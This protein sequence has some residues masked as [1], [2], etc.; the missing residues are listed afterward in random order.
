MHEQSMKYL[1]RNVFFVK[2]STASSEL[3]AHTATLLLWLGR[4]PSG[5]ERGG[6]IRD[7][8]NASPLA[9][10]IGG[11]GARLLF[12]ELLTTLSLEQSPR[13]LL[14]KVSESDLWNAVQDFLQGTWPYEERMDEWN[15]YQIACFGVG[16]AE[17]EQAV[18]VLC[19]C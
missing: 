2:I 9:I 15:A 3:S 17:L 11:R 16:V 1:G 10:L 6:I 18:R 19:D 4:E 12:D 8:L 5:E 7:V 14:T 13:A